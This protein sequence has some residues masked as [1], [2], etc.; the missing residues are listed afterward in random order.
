MK[1]QSRNK[2][3][4]RGWPG[5]TSICAWRERRVRTEFLLLVG[6]GVA[7]GAGAKALCGT[8]DVPENWSRPGA[9]AISLNIVVVP[10]VKKNPVVAPPFVIQP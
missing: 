1:Y 9:R 6:P 10:A 7:L 8:L 4:I 3:F 2:S 5:V